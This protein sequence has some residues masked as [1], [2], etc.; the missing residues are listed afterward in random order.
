M[1]RTTLYIYI[2]EKCAR[3]LRPSGR[4]WIAKSIYY[5]AV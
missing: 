5:W 4:R 2:N 1:V 3:K